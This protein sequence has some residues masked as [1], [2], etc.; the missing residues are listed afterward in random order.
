MGK[1]IRLL[2]LRF[3]I[4]KMTA[5]L[6]PSK[7]VVS[8]NCDEAGTKVTQA[9]VAA[10]TSTGSFPCPVRSLCRQ[11]PPFL[12]FVRNNGGGTGAAGSTAIW[13]THSFSQ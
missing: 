8:L 3:L 1:I 11:P 7:I 6:P 10:L 4:C 9:V 5:I 13:L 12:L 2:S